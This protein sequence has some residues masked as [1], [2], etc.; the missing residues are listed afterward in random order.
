M[1]SFCDDYF[2]QGIN[3]DFTG[4][5]CGMAGAFHLRVTVEHIVHIGMGATEQGGR[6]RSAPE[7]AGTAICV[8]ILSRTLREHYTILIRVIPMSQA[9]SLVTDITVPLT[10]PA[11]KS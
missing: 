5:P 8:L 1:S 11:K 6:P 3:E 4:D 2:E 10:I 9:V 7:E